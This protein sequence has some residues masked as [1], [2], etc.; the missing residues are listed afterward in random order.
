MASSVDHWIPTP[1]S[2]FV[3]AHPS[4]LDQIS[5]QVC[6]YRQLGKRKATGRD[7]LDSASDTGRLRMGREPV[8]GGLLAGIAG[9]QHA[10]DQSSFRRSD[11]VNGP[12]DGE[13]FEII[14][15]RNAACADDDAIEAEIGLGGK[16][17][18]RG[19]TDGPV[20]TLRNDY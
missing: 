3:V 5:Q 1:E 19:V 20:G 15:C 9:C 8:L 2:H 11:L 7:L 6:R 10:G 16:E 17:R 4:V 14:V 13:T 18:R 12:I